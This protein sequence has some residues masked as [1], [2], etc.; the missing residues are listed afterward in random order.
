M[1]SLMES[2]TLKLPHID[3]KYLRTMVSL[4]K[5]ICSQ[6]KPN[7]AKIIYDKLGSKN[8][9][10]FSQGWGDRLQDFMVVKQVSIILVLTHEK[11][12]IQSIINNGVL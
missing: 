6:F 5:Y 2:Y 3:K 9:L 4:R 8:V 11:K 1:T 10:D 7:V 12:I